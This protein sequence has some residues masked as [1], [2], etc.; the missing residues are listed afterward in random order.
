M[1]ELRTPFRL[2]DLLRIQATETICRS[3]LT[4]Q[5]PKVMEKLNNK[6]NGLDRM[7]ISILSR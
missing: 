3:A 6:L 7:V 2:E 4:K 1:K 5:L